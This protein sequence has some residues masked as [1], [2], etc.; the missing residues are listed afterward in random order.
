VSLFYYEH[1]GKVN[2]CLGNV[3]FSQKNHFV[4]KEKCIDMTILSEEL[5][6]YPNAEPGKVRYN[7]NMD[8]SITETKNE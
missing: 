3:S 1:G 6:D 4:T 2:I 7:S 5:P 8:A